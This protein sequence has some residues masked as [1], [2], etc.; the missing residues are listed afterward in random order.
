MNLRTEQDGRLRRITMASPELRGSTQ[1]PDNAAAMKAVNGTA[2]FGSNPGWRGSC[3]CSEPGDL[4][5]ADG[6]CI[7]ASKREGSKVVNA[8]AAMEE[9]M[10][11]GS[12]SCIC[13]VDYDCCDKYYCYYYC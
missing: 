1:T 6:G 9:K 13:P 5:G 8:A 12:T 2:E 11:S 10:P 3:A 7:Q 4:C